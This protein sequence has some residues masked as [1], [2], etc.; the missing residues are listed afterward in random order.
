MCD[1]SLWPQLR[2]SL[3]KPGSWHQNLV[4]HLSSQVQEAGGSEDPEQWIEPLFAE[5]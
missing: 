5:N 1:Y 3:P 4:C 2:G